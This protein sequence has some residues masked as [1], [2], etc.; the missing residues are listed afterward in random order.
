LASFAAPHRA[1]WNGQAVERADNA[2]VDRSPERRPLTRAGFYI[3]PMVDSVSISDTVGT[4]V[5]QAASYPD[6]RA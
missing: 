6:R 3:I 5:F 4:T 2:S 1:A